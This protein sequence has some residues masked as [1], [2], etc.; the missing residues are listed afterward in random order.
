[1]VAVTAGCS[2]GDGGRAAAPT[3]LPPGTITVDRWSPPT[4]TGGPGQANF[5]SALTA[6]YQHMGDLPHVISRKVTESII[7]DYVAYAPTVVAQ[8]PPAIHPSAAAYIGAVST[9]LHELIQSGLDQG[10][11]PTGS[12][13]T[14]STPALR[15]DY[16]D[17]FG[18]T[19]T[20]CHYTI[21]GGS[22][23]PS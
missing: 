21:G 11:L 7:G 15:T 17:V 9:Y 16:S 8:A 2:G 6:I 5:C 18:Y 10:H 20:Q 3:T 19:Q 13:A 12:L 22:S 23:N 1:M 4:L 14:L